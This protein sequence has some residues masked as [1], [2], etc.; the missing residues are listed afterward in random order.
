MKILELEGEAEATSGP[1][2]L[3]KTELEEEEEWLHT[4]HITF[5]QTGTESHREGSYPQ[6]M[7]SPVGK[8]RTQSG[9]PALPALW[10]ASLK[11]HSS[12]ASWRWWGNLQGLITDQTVTESGGGAY[13]NEYLD[14][15]RLSS[16][17]EK[18]PSRNLN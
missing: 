9:Y 4:D 18:Y 8:K 1:Q 15:G 16:S 12:L 14:L 2:I 3:R 13:N 7:V 6:P 10:I 5:F 17:L 11:V